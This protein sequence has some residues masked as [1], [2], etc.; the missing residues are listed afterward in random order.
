MKMAK[1]MFKWIGNAA[2]A[3]LVAVA[4]LSVVSFVRS[5]GT[6]NYIPGIGPYKFLAVLSGSMSPTF[7]TYDMIVDKQ[8]STE[9]LK[10]GDVITSWIDNSLVTHR[11]AEVIKRDGNTFFR[12]KGDANNVEDEREIPS[13]DV[14]GK[15][16]FHIPYLGLVM[17][18]IR[19]PIGIG[20]VWAIF[21][22]IAI[23]EILS[24]VRKSKKKKGEVE[25]EKVLSLDQGEKADANEIYVKNFGSGY[26]E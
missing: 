10:Q 25:C 4:V 12:T 6:E 15:L 18:K 1:L 11:I 22:Y 5:K 23:T 7:N 2:L 19:G 3:V 17:S 14:V 13:K 8:I 24:E 26:I 16:L 20:V 21:V 9:T